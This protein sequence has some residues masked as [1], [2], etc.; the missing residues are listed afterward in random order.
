MWVAVPAHDNE[1]KSS[2]HVFLH[3]HDKSKIEKSGRLLKT[4]I[5]SI[6]MDETSR[7]KLRLF[8][9]EPMFLHIPMRKNVHIQPNFSPQHYVVELFASHFTKHGA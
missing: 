2:S 4:F 6:S 8:S 7:R 1:A 9:Y 3:D 5:K